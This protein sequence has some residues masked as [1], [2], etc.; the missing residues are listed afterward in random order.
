MS[1]AG[2]TTQRVSYYLD[3]QRCVARDR[4]VAL[5]RVVW[6][7]VVAPGWLDSLANSY[8]CC[9]EVDVFSV[10]EAMFPLVA[11]A[12]RRVLA[13]PRT[14]K[15]NDPG[16]KYGVI[17]LAARAPAPSC[18]AWISNHREQPTT[19]TAAAAT[20][21]ASQVRWNQQ[22]QIR[23]QNLAVKEVAATLSGL[24]MGGHVQAARSLMGGDYDGDSSRGT[25][26]MLWDGRRVAT[27]WVAADGYVDDVTDCGGGGE[28]RRKVIEYVRASCESKH[29]I[30]GNVCESEN[31][32]LA[33]WLLSV[34]GIGWEDAPWFLCKS[35]KGWTPRHLRIC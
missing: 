1:S 8:W 23:R 9:G 18:I 6:D 15:G 19:T 28:L 7:M 13:L 17:T 27:R 11:L 22:D 2:T 24:C 4:V 33:K 14:L 30:L 32:E 12:C 10:A 25:L 26:P 21:T 16:S 34:L 35:L 29:S 20:I 3:H 5:S 31:V